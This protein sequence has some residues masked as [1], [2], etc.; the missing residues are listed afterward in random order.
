MSLECARPHVSGAFSFPGEANMALKWNQLSG[1]QRKAILEEL[2]PDLP[3]KL[4]MKSYDDV[5]EIRKVGRHR[6]AP[7]LYL[8]VD[9]GGTR[10]WVFRYMHDGKAR[11]MGLGSYPKVSY[12]AAL[13]R[14]RELRQTFFD[15]VAVRHEAEKRRRNDEHV[16]GIAA[17][18][19]RSDRGTHNRPMSERKRRRIVRSLKE[20]GVDVDPSDL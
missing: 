17:W 6:V 20:E 4:K 3:A 7:R 19:P 14:V 10:S 1:Q 12:E 18:L 9:S 2:W 8:N 5:D 15:P 16:P 13:V 11:E